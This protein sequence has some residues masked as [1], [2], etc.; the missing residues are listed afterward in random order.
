MHIQLPQ[1]DLE[2]A[3]TV[4]SNLVDR[5]ANPMPVL[6][7]L[8]IEATEQGVVFRG[9]DMET[10]V[11]VNANATVVKPGRTT[12]PADT[13]REIVKLLPPQGEVTI[14]E[15]GRKVT[16][17]CETNE[18][19]LMTIPAD[20]FPDWQ[21]DPGHSKFQVSQKTLKFMID[22]TLYALPSKDH[23]RVL[24]GIFMELGDNTL[25]M[26]STDGKKLARVSTSIPEVE[27][28]GVGTLVVPRK[29]MENL[30]KVLGNE[31]PVEIELSNRQIVLRFGNIIYR[32]NGIEGK[33]PD[34]DSVIPKEFP[35]EL[36][37]NR[38]VFLQGSRRA[39]VTTDE[40]NKSIILKFEDNKVQFLSTAHDLGAFHGQINLDYSGPSLELAFNYQFLNETLSRFASPDVRMFIKSPTAPVVFRSRDE[41]NRLA[42]LMPI[43]LADIRPVT[44][45]GDEDEEEEE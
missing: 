25:R 41:D 24:L 33:Y 11:T 16:V 39:G 5:S 31:G 4:V 32:C 9:T 3:A 28:T 7:N 26:T 6:A 14:Q 45:G 42:L 2:A 17:E 37:L 13:F 22:S 1:K 21:S 38:D 30:L 10:L 12:V 18:Y 15:A 20:D 29:L 8:L 40:K 43:K 36:A 44:V 27:G 35:I 19:K 23:R 34:C